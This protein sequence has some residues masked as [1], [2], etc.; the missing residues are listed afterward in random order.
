MGIPY[1]MFDKERT[2]REVRAA[3]NLETVYHAGQRKIWNGQEVLAQLVEKHGVPDLPPDKL[4][5]L[6]R[7]FSIIMWG[8][9]AA[10][11]ISAELAADLEPMEA[12]MAA[13]SQA[14]D[15]ARHF[16]VMHD[17]LQH[18]GYEPGPLGGAADRLLTA[19]V[20]TGSLTRKLLGM[21]LMVEPVAITLFQTVR[22]SGVEP[23][24]CELLS[25]YERDEARHIALGV[26]YLPDLLNSMSYSDLLLL[27]SW[28]LRLLFLQVD[29]LKELEDDLRLLG[30]DPLAVFEVAEA[31]Q[32]KALEETLEHTGI[33]YLIEPFKYAVR[34]K[35]DRIFSG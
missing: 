5:A 18:L 16:Y 1:G 20:D 14:H 21:Q 26:N 24:L 6:K 11:K 27:W 29:E 8:E 15:E 2:A 22:Q 9:M 23:V 7:I 4:N 33:P 34:L 25:F 28:Q 19:V 3:R 30:I 17:Y 10:W 31:K 32:I 35:R 12:R 13:T